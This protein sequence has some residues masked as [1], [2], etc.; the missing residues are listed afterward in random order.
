MERLIINSITM[1]KI[2]PYKIDREERFEMIGSFYQIVTGLKNKK[3][4]AGFFM[5]LLTPS[6]A[7]MFARRIQIAQMLLSDKSVSEIRIALGVGTNNISTVS[8]WLFNDDNDVFRKHI[9]N[10]LKQ[11]KK[12]TAKRSKKKSRQYYTSELDKYPQHRMWKK[13]LGL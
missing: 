5:G 12:D 4:V 2:R 11:S 9:L 7:V 13:L 1:A 3:D 8:R 6:E 10:Y